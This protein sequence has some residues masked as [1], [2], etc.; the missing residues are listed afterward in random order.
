MREI[1][2]SNCYA[3]CNKIKYRHRLHFHYLK[4]FDDRLGETTTELSR[5]FLG[6]GHG[7]TVGAADGG[8]RRARRLGGLRLNLNRFHAAYRSQQAV[9][10]L[11]Y[12]LTSL[13]GNSK[14]T[15]LGRETDARTN[16]LR[17]RPARVQMLLLLSHIQ[18]RMIV[19]SYHKKIKTLFDSSIVLADVKHS[20]AVSESPV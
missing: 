14:P 19:C 11:T 7:V 6:G 4:S 3:N 9:Y 1:S 5:K 17:P 18:P 20:T 13:R 16:A 15:G 10:N 8:A 2:L 12:C